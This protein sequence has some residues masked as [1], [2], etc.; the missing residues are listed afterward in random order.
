[1]LP[2]MKMPAFSIRKTVVLASAIASMKR[3]AFLVGHHLANTENFL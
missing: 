1:M 2:L 3:D